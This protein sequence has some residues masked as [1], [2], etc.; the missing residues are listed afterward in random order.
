MPASRPDLKSRCRLTRTRL[1][2]SDG[3]KI[4][5]TKSGP[6]TWS[7]FLAIFGEENLRRD[8]PCRRAGRRSDQ[9]S[10]LKP[11]FGVAAPTLQAG[12]RG[13]VRRAGA[14]ASIMSCGGLVS[15]PG[16][17]GA[18]SPRMP[19]GEVVMPTKSAKRRPRKA[20]KAA[21]SSKSAARRPKRHEPESLR[22]RHITPG[23][24]V[25]DLDSEHSVLHRARIHRPGAVGRR[26]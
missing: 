5:S 16:P 1:L 4:R 21:R 14:A 6:G 13:G 18:L 17:S 2:R 10:P 19:P 24:T 25:N 12:C 20:A 7:R 8:R 26:G 11:R 23:I 15:H 3:A 9:Y 22:L